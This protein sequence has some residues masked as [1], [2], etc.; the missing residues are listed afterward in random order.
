M[1]DGAAVD[2]IVEGVMP[3]HEQAEEILAAGVL[4]TQAGAVGVTIRFPRA[5]SLAS[6]VVVVVVKEIIVWI[7]VTVVNE[8]VTEVDVD[9]ETSTSVDTT[10]S[11]VFDLTP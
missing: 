4:V 3:K 8:V 1:V 10:V 7:A 5:F 2:V 9:D 11:T 6:I